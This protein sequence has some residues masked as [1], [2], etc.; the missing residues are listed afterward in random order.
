M[1]LKDLKKDTAK[2]FMKAPDNNILEYVL[3]KKVILVEGDAEFI[4]MEKFFKDIT[5]KTPEE[6]DV[7]IISVD[8][9]SFKRYLEISN[10]LNIKTAVIRDNDGN[11]DEIMNSFSEYENNKKVEIFIDSDNKMTTF[12]VGLYENN[13]E[14]CKELFN[15]KKL[16]IQQ[17]ML[18]NKTECAFRLLENQIKPLIISNY[19]KEAIEWIKE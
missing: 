11:R 6:L 3:S 15:P 18:N 16:T 14:I 8:G 7:H 9:I 12:E 1:Y 13:K 19:I 5:D 4:L 2:F 10:I 17:Y